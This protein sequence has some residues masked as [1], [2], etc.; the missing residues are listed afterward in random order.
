MHVNCVFCKIIARE[1]PATIIAENDAVI[2][3]KDIYPQAPIHYLIIPKMHI[4]DMSE[5]PADKGKVAA[6]LLMMAQELSQLPGCKQFKLQNNNGPRAGQVV[7]HIHI[8][9]LAGF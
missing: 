7:F 9:F 5:L 4:V 6:A 8:H 2:V 3:I 1:I